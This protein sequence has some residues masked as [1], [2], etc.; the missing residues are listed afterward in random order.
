MVR[1]ALDEKNIP[2]EGKHIKLCDQYP[3]G[4]NIEKKFLKINPLGTVPVINING[5]ITCNSEEIIKKLNDIKGYSEKNL[6]IFDDDKS[7]SII[8]ETTITEGVKF[9]STLGT[10]MPVFSAPLIQ[11]MVKKLPF[12]SIVKI[13]LKHPRRDRKYFFLTMYFFDLTK[14]LTKIAVKKFVDELIKFES[15]LSQDNLYF[16]KNFSHIDINMMCLFNRLND[17]KLIECLN[18]KKTP[19][20]KNYWKNLQQRDSYKNSILKYYTIKELND[21]DEFYQ[22]KKSPFLEPIL[23]ELYKRN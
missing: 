10:I 4:E 14:T 2:F 3:E 13:F 11:H 1:V 9:A 7:N 12:R 16:Y 20:I 15:Y 5:D 21:M 22:N 6:Y 23:S 8:K 19:L 17:L 18:T